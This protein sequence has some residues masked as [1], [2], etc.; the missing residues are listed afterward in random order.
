[1]KD[2]GYDGPADHHW[3]RY[4]FLFADLFTALAVLFL[5]ANTVGHVPPPPS[6]LPTPVV[7]KPSPTPRICGLEPTPANLPLLTVGDEAGLRVGSPTAEAA[8][9]LQV[10]Q[11]LQAN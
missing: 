2:R 5:V 6:S 3:G 10:R 11:A 4:G 9:A 7:V 1:M 8:F